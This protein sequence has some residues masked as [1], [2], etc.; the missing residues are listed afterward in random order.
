[1]SPDGAVRAMIGGRQLQ[2]LG[3]FNRSTQALRQPGSAF[4]PIVYAA[5]LEQGYKPN[6]LIRDEA[7]EIKIPGSGIWTP[8]NNEKKFNGI[9]SLTAA[10]S[11]SLNLSLIHI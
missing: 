8:Q 1:M 10:L 6:D 5:A 4:K 2:V 7:F 9:V 3:A 11:K